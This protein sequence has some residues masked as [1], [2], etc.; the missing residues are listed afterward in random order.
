MILGWLL[1]M[2]GSQSECWEAGNLPHSKLP[3]GDWL[4]F[5]EIRNFISFSS[6]DSD[7]VTCRRELRFNKQ[8]WGEL[9]YGTA[10]FSLAD[11][12]SSSYGCPLVPLGLWQFPPWT[13][14]WLE[15]WTAD[16]NGS[17]SPGFCYLFGLFMFLLH[18]QSKKTKSHARENQ[19]PQIWKV[20]PFPKPL[21]ALLLLLT[22]TLS[23]VLLAR[24]LSP[25]FSLSSV[26]PGCSSE[27][28]VL[29]LFLLDNAQSPLIS[30]CQH[31]FFRKPSL[32][33]WH[34]RLC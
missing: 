19:T 4:A 31:W 23:R 24:P 9:L 30:E 2:S 34:P 21:Y 28:S 3:L 26:F 13:Y 18:K 8:S 1:S 29:A 7:G 32:P 5:Y 12:E 25:S 27:P 10:L 17:S 15:A 6:K 33:S 11:L 14:P 22:L 20:P 16:T